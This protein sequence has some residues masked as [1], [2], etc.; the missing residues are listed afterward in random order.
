MKFLA[1]FVLF[2]LPYLI[3]Q[4]TMTTVMTI[5]GTPSPSPTERPTISGISGST[6][7]IRPFGSY[8][9]SDVHVTCLHRV[10]QSYWTW[11]IPTKQYIMGILHGLSVVYY[12]NTIEYTSLLQ[13]NDCRAW[14]VLLHLLKLANPSFSL[15]TC[16]LRKYR[17]SRGTAW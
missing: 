17:T 10:T 4:A 11:M 8:T 16:S 3:R 6:K 5:A 13:N 12:R 14:I 7:V 2:F 1:I 9:Y 15:L